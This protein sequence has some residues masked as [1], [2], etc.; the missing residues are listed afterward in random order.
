[1]VPVPVVLYSPFSD[2]MVALSTRRK[3][4]NVQ[5]TT[6]WAASDEVDYQEEVASHR[7]G[8]VW[9]MAHEN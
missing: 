3:R 2:R 5:N 9:G 7:M 6:G 1:M 4:H 8:W